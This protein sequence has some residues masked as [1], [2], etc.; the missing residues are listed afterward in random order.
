MASHSKR[1]DY[2]EVRVASVRARRTFRPYPIELL[3]KLTDR[4]HGTGQYHYNEQVVPGYWAAQCVPQVHSET[5][6][7]RER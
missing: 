3:N 4:S 5:R 6:K 7:A 2:P 1:S